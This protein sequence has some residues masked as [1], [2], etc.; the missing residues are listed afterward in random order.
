M[1]CFLLGDAAI[2]AGFKGVKPGKTEGFVR[3]PPLITVDGSKAER[4]LGLKY[5]TQEETAVDSIRSYY[6]LFP[7]VNPEK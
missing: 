3:E 2:K 6:E 5:R 7:D 4:V 1:G